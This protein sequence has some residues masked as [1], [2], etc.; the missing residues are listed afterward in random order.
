MKRNWHGRP[1]CSSSPTTRGGPQRRSSAATSAAAEA[2]LV[3]PSPAARMEQILDEW[4]SVAVKAP[5]DAFLPDLASPD[6]FF[7]DLGTTIRSADRGATRRLARSV[8]GLRAAEAALTRTEYTAADA[9]AVEALARQH[10][11]PPIDLWARRVRLTAAYFAGRA[12]EG[13]QE[14]DRLLPALRARGYLALES[15]VVS[16][17]AALDY[18][19]GSYDRALAGFEHVTELRA[20]LRDTKGA[21]SGHMLAA[22]AYRAMGRD[23]EAW[24]HYLRVLA[25]GAIPTDP[26]VAHV[27]LT[28]PSVGSLNRRAP[29]VALALA[30]EAEHHARAERHA[31]FLT[32]ALYLQ[33]RAQAMLGA[34]AEAEELISASQGALAEIADPSAHNRF[35]AEVLFA[36]AEV[37]VTSRPAASVAAAV[38]ASSRF[39]SNRTAHRLL[40]LAV[41]EARAWR[42]LARPADAETALR[43]GVAL[44]E[45]QQGQIARS[46]FLPSFL[47][48][49]WDVYS[50]LVDLKA[51]GNDAEGAVQWLDRGYDV[52]RRWQGAGGA[53]SWAQVSAAGPVVA[54][55]SRRDALWVWVVR[56]GAVHQRRVPVTSRALIDRTTRLTRLLAQNGVDAALRTEAAALAAAVLWPATDGFTGGDIGRLA[57]VLDP[58]LQQVPFAMLPWSRRDNRA[59]VDVAATVLCPSVLACAAA[60]D[61]GGIPRGRVAALYSS[62]GTGDLAPLPLAR[63][64]AERIGRRYA[65]ATVDIASEATMRAALTGADLVHFA[66]HAAPDEQYPGRSMLV[67]TEGG[68]PGARVPVSR[69]LAG[70]V[71][72]QT[73]LLSACRTSS[74]E[75]RRGHGG[76]GVAGEFLRAGVRHVVAAQWDVQDQA[77][78]DVMDLVHEALATGAQPWDAVRH[79]QRVFRQDPA[80]RPRDWAGY[81]A[82]TSASSPPEPGNGHGRSTPTERER[83]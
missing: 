55:L 10:D 18:A 38:K 65:G 19:D 41:V 67:L 51:A 32:E 12:A 22:E 2:P 71:Q 33:A 62:S 7:T 21:A 54:Y 1:I 15:D 14:A 46:D 17:L 77:A 61:P 42:A 52:R 9:L 4:A 79:A 49:S 25:V 27:R 36:E 11:A 24:E 34:T 26:V 66:G 83:P 75:Q 6:P 81:V 72:V 8:Q 5:A 80:R 59:A 53:V 56:D 74:A 16:R 69:L 63:P 82:F 28:S 44:V 45:A 57:L 58:V 30:R 70:G 13:R 3:A 31:G 47:D 35:E 60:P 73:V 64:E 39:Q 29:E 37:F 78:S 40:A 50:E 48:A 23:A 76:T 43:K 20:R 68:G